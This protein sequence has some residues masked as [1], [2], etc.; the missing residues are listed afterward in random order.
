MPQ[1]VPDRTTATPKGRTEP[2]MNRTRLAA[3]IAALALMLGLDAGTAAA[4]ATPVTIVCVGA[5][6]TH[7]NPP[8]TNTT[9]NTTAKT[10]E[11]HNCTP[12]PDVSSAHSTHTATSPQSCVLT[13]VPPTN[14]STRTYTWNNG[15][16]STITFFSSTVVTLVNG[17][18]VLTFIGTVTDGLGE[19]GIATRVVTLPSLNPTA[20]ATTGISSLTGTVTLEIVL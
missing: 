8:L 19:G 1:P 13:L 11:D 10:T 9:Q 7:Y 4:Q 15:Q 3:F 6:T 17:F 14:T 16:R 2:L 5:Q 18:K 12:L 20:C